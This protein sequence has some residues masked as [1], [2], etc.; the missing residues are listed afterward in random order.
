MGE[1]IKFEPGPWE[2]L[3]ALALDSVTSPHSKRAYG[4]ALNHFLA[5]YH[6]ESRPPVSKAVVNAY[7]AQLEE[8]HLSASTIN[9]RLAAVRRLVSEAA[10]N[11]LISP[12]LAAGIAKVKGASRLGVRTGNWLDR[13]QAERLINA[14]N[15]ATIAGRRDRALFSVLIGCGLRRS[16]AAALTFTHIQQREGR[17]VIVDL[18][19]KHGRIRSVPMPAWAKIAIDEWSAA[20]GIHI[21][22][23]FRPVNKGDRVT[24]GS[25]SGN[26]IRLV[27]RKYTSELG[28]ANLAPHDLRRTYAR[29]AHQGRAKLE[30][31]Q[32]SLGHASVQTTERYLGVRQNLADA[33]CDHLRMKLYSVPTGS[34]LAA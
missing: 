5:W 16:E 8:A 6:S 29:L 24:Q 25:L 3:K 21:G 12:D 11:G 30:Q 10:D 26:C 23:V 31:I 2:K 13:R 17:W 34:K 15:T 1:L 33:P 18:V 7:K 27:L 4:S 22:P 19:G 14:P 9:V 20:S 32:I 28:V